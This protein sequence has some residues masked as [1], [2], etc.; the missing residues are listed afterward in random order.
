[1]AL[2]NVI[3]AYEPFNEQETIDKEKILNYIDTF[4]DVLTRNNELAH[5]TSS[6]FVVNKSRDKVLVTYHNV[7]NSW[8]WAGGHADGEED[9]LHVAMREVNEETGLKNLKP[10]LNDIFLLDTSI[11]L[12][13]I[14]NGKLIPSHTHLSAAYLLEAS[15]NEKL[16]VNKN[17]N[18]DVR[19]IPIEKILNE[20]TE[21]YMK[22]I[23]AK[24]IAKIEKYNL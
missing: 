15:E 18:S 22:R 23:F 9:L 8:T 4:D 21:P 20:L 12:E 14:K 17:E 7:Y 19:W 5:F 10:V 13:H 16:I 2:K 11:T 1:M 3:K 24:A 6:G